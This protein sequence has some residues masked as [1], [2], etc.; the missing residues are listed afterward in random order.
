MMIWLYQEETQ[1]NVF[2]SINVFM[3]GNGVRDGRYVTIS[4]IEGNL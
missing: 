4:P 1:A 2:L 3:T